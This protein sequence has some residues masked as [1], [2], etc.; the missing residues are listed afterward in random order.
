MLRAILGAIF[1][2]VIGL[3]IGG[4]IPASWWWVLAPLWAPVAVFVAVVLIGLGLVA[5]VDAVQK[6]D[7]S[8]RGL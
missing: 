5:I 7:G 4:V 1:G 8:E 6:C 3:K 2:T